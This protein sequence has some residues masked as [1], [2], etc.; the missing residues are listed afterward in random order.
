VRWDFVKEVMVEKGFPDIWISQTMSTIQGGRVCININGERSK[1]FNTYQ[2]LKQGDP[3]SPIMFNLVAELLATL[4]KKAANQGK[5]EGVMSHLLPEGI[6]HIQYADDTILM[7]EGDEQSIIYMKFIL[8]CFEWLSDLKINYHKSEAYVFE[9][10][11]EKKWKISNMLNCRLG[12]MPLKYLGVPISAIK[13]GMGAFDRVAGKVAKRVPPWKGK[14]MY[15]GARL[16]LSNSCLTSLPTYTMGFYLLPLGSH[17]KM[18]SRRAK[19][20]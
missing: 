6:T 20:F 4:M 19:F 16:I 18:N 12:E 17:R 9:M 13:L 2:G 5:I 1:F 3:P 10:D 15:S 7:V 8:H 14:L 11:E